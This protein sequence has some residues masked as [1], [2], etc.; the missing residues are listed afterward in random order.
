MKAPDGTS[1]TPLVA[2]LERDFDCGVLLPEAPDSY[3]VPGAY[4]VLGVPGASGA[5]G[6]QGQFAGLS[7]ALWEK[8]L[9]GPARQFLQ[10]PG[11]EFRARL[12]AM[13][14]R[15][16]GGDPAALPDELPLVVELLHAGSLIVDDIQDQSAVRRG[17]PALHRLVGTAVAL[18]TGNWLYFWSLV[19]LGRNVPA[20]RAAAVQARASK[21]L[22]HCHQGQAL[23][24]AVRAC[25]LAR[26]EVAGAVA[27]TT[28][29]KTGALM[30]FAAVL[31]AS[32]A[33]AGDARCDTLSRFGHGLGVG[34]QM[35]DDLGCLVD[36]SRRHKAMEDVAAARLT[37]PWAW[38]AQGADSRAF[39]AW[40]ARARGLA[41]IGPETRD[42]TACTEF[43]ADL[44][45]AVAG[46]G[47][48][49][50]AEYLARTMDELRAQLGPSC[51]LGDVEHEIARLEKSYG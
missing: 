33:G 47:R 16:A 31:G 49:H 29:L 2:L 26:D 8:A 13:G 43:V 23:D 22:M 17:E 4:D 39:A 15:L 40:Q 6:G 5:P 7:R 35:L 44:A 1:R 34:L 37:W 21:T 18:N 36:V 27:T 20:D 12:V 41:E 28:A 10:R 9:L 11:K 46:P 45:E 24:L 42:Q 3:N 50:V 48:R 51:D 32:A 19:V 30:E 25:D 14:W 38:L